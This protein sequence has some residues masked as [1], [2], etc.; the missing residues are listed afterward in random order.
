[1]SGTIPPPMAPPPP[2]PPMPPGGWAPPK[3][4]SGKAVAALVCGLAGPVAAFFCP[5]FGIA[6]LVGLILGVIGIIET[7]KNGSRSGRGM[8][9]AGTAVS[10]LGIAG[11][12]AIVTAFVALSN[13]EDREQDERREE[14]IAE[15]QELLTS[16]LQEYCQAN[17][18]SLGPGGPVLAM[19]KPQRN[20]WDE[21][22]QNMP[23][24]GRPIGG[25]VTNRLELEHLVGENELRWSGRRGGRGWELV[26]T[27]QKSA[28]LQARRWDGEVVREI[29]IRDASRGMWV[30]T[31]P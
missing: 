29:E 24:E 30:Q 20:E 28:T 3:P 4:T 26:I 8:A 31:V 12:I 7:G 6:V 13:F 21:A 17:D 1:M 22:P 10:A 19:D 23:H 2:P 16:R 15:D 14:R 11:T 27:G 18:G 9:I 25:T 5:V